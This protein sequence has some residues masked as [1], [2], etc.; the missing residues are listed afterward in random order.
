MIQITSNPASANIL[1][2][3]YIEIGL[4]YTYVT[5]SDYKWIFNYFDENAVRNMKLGS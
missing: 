3:V 4:S 2:N 1:F 5:S